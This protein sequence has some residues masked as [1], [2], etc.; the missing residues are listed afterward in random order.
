MSVYSLV[1]TV[2]V[3]YL[4]EQL[5]TKLFKTEK[6]KDLKFLKDLIFRLFKNR[7]FEKILST[8]SATERPEAHIRRVGV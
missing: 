6:D 7:K 1:F 8:D 4:E 5:K 3:L 2:V